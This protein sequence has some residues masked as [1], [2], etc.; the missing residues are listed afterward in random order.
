VTDHAW[1]QRERKGAGAFGAKR[2]VGSGS[3]GREDRTRSD[4][5]HERLFIETKWRLKHTV[6][7]LWDKVAAF[8][9]KEKKTPVLLLAEKGR[10][11][12][13][14]VC[15]LDDLPTVA[16]EYAAARHEQIR[17]TLPGQTSFVE[18]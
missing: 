17:Q 5:T 14:V 12:L 11:G 18:G 13:W 16:A 9:K 15:K 8:A 3:L 7:S 4:S 10:P 6:V 2:T 1:K